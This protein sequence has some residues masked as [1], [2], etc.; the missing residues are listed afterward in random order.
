MQLRKNK[1]LVT[2]CT[3]QSQL[4]TFKV[5]LLTQCLLR[6]ILAIKSKI[7]AYFTTILFIQLILDYL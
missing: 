1:L 2:L 6:G 5:L 4:I 7:P 3:I